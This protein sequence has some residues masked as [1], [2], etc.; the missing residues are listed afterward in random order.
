MELGQGDG[1][2]SVPIGKAGI[3]VAPL[4]PL[5]AAPAGFCVRE[6]ARGFPLV[7]G[8]RSDGT[9]YLVSPADRFYADSLP[10]SLAEWLSSHARHNARAAAVA[11]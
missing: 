1:A 4:M 2:D 3:G 10:T 8:C 5:W 11:P 7:L 9:E 6:A